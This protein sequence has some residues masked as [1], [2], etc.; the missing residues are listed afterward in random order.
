MDLIPQLPRDLDYP[1]DCVPKNYTRVC[2]LGIF[3][4]TLSSCKRKVPITV[5]KSNR[6]LMTVLG[7]DKKSTWGLISGSVANPKNLH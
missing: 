4:P 5:S 6:E 2:F 7:G 3:L 1:K